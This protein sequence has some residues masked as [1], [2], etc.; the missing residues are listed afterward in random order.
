MAGKTTRTTR[1]AKP[2]GRFSEEQVKQFL[3]QGNIQTMEDVQSALKDLFSQTL[4]AMLDGELDNHLGYPK[5]GY[6]RNDADEERATTNRRNG[7]TAKNVRSDYG[8][9]A[10]SVPRDR[11]GSF[12]PL[13]V[14]KRQKNVTGIEEQILALYTKGVS[15]RDIQDHL[16]RIYGI[17]VSPTF[18]SDVTDRIIPQIRA[19]QS[20]PLAP[21]YA[22]MFLDAIHFKVRHEGRIVSKAA[23]VIIGVDMEGIK[24]VLGIWIGEA[25]SSKFWLSV[26]TELKNRGTQ[27]ILICCIDNLSGFSEA[28]GAVFP[29]AQIQKCIVH[30]VR[31]S[32]KYVSSRDR[33]PVVCALRQVYTAPSESAGLVALEEFESAWGARYPLIVRSWRSHWSELSLFFGFSVE[34]RR[35]I[36]TTNIIESFHRQLRKVTRGKALFPT[37]ESLLKMLYLVT[38]DVQRHWTYRLPHW[39][40]ILS[41]L[42]VAYGERAKLER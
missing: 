27:D 23:Y 39:G 34:L 41:Q 9:I 13:I 18:V 36:Y 28:I 38:E 11:D 17:E 14:Q 4:Q 29:A 22:L 1:A 26:L 12:E 37:D 16:Q 20:R 5:N 7:R 3:E 40:Q 42:S 33:Q 6:P 8:D 25:E 2:S 19:W 15:T 31:N 35:L 10:L 30:Q 21:L 32:L 24:E